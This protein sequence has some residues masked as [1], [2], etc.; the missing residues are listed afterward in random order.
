MRWW[1]RRVD[2]AW[3]GSTVPA[4][5]VGSGWVLGIA[6]PR[7]VATSWTVPIPLATPAC[8]PDSPM[9]LASWASSSPVHSTTGVSGCR[10]RRIRVGLD[11]VHPGHAQVHEHHVGV[12][13]GGLGQGLGAVGGLADHRQPGPLERQADA[14]A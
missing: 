8:A 1:R 5:S 4:I 2:G 14:R 3:I 9:A 10:R 6:A 11:A 7:K 13:R 12:V